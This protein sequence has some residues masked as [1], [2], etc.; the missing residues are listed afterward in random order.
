LTILTNPG[1]SHPVQQIIAGE[2]TDEED[3]TKE[4]LKLFLQAD[5]DGLGSISLREYTEFSWLNKN[6][7]FGEPMEEGGLSAQLSKLEKKVDDIVEKVNRLCDE[8]APP[9][10]ISWAH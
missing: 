7:P 2:D 5:T 4:A 10:T 8:L 9:K 3:G 1:L 6:N